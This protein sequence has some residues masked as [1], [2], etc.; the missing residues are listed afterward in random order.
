VIEG[1]PSYYKWVVVF[2]LVYIESEADFNF[3]RVSVCAC[4]Y[5]LFYWAF[6]G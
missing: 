3:H 5:L 1:D 6:L 2:Q 4:L